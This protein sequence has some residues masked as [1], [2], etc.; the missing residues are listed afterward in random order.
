MTSKWDDDERRLDAEYERR[1]PRRRTITLFVGLTRD[2]RVVVGSDGPVK[3]RFR[4]IVDDSGWVTI[5]K[6]R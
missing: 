5:W 4:G 6:G 1:A 3:R 2:G